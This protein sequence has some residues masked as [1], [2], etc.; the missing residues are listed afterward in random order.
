MKFPGTFKYDVTGISAG[1]YCKL[2]SF[3]K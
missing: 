1:S 3:Y 2:G